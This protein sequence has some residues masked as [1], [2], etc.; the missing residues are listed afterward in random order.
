VKRILAAIG[1]L[2]TVAGLAV[3]PAAHAATAARTYY[4]ALGGTAATCAA[5]TQATPF[6]HSRRHRVRDG[7]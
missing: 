4:V 1:G 2:G 5:D 6:P 7:R 3:M